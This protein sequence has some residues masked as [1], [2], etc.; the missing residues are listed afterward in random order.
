MAEQTIQSNLDS[1]SQVI[2][3]HI[4]LF[5]LKQSWHLCI[6]RRELRQQGRKGVNEEW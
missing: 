6:D 1:W 3:T 2:L 5:S 4:W